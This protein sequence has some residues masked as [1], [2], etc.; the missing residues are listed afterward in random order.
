[1]CVYVREIE[2]ERDAEERM[3]ES[4]NEVECECG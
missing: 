3:H 2:R 4:V 1:M